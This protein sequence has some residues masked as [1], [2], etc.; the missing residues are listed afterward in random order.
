MQVASLLLL[1]VR[2]ENERAGRRGWITCHAGR[3]IAHSL[4][5]AHAPTRAQWRLIMAQGSHHM[6]LPAAAS[7]TASQVQPQWQHTL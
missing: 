6:V 2:E 7:S 3:G 5:M 1:S 4:F